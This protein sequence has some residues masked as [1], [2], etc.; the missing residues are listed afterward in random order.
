MGLKRFISREKKKALG[1]VDRLF[2]PDNDGRW[3]E[4]LENANR[5]SFVKAVQGDPRADTKLQRHVDQMNRLQMGKV[6]ASVPGGAGKT[7]DIVRKRGGGLA[8]TCPD[9]RY[10]QSV[11][12]DGEQDC[13]HIKKYRASGGRM[14]KTAQVVAAYESALKEAGFVDRA[15]KILKGENIQAARRGVEG[16]ALHLDDTKE[17]LKYIG[18]RSVRGVNVGLGSSAYKRQLGKVDAAQKRLSE[19]Q[20]LHRSEV[21]RTVGAH[22]AWAVPTAATLAYGA[23]RIRKSRKEKQQ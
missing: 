16:A 5:K 13:K 11:K 4:F 20:R 1:R 10:K 6:V 2:A 18:E 3:D 14:N 22:A 8:C 12:S 21:G 19:A 7:Y 17:R 9:W 15:K 23:H